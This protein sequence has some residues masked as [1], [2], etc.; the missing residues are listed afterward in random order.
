MMAN[1]RKTRWKAWGHSRGKTEA[2]L[3]DCTKTIEKMVL[4]SL[5]GLTVASTKDSGK[6]VS[7]MV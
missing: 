4:V 7:N 1:G 3:K 5:S 2:H 6:A